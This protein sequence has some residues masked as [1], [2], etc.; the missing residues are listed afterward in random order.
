MDNNFGTRVICTWI[1]EEK[2]SKL[3]DDDGFNV[4]FELCVIDYLTIV[5]R[6][7]VTLVVGGWVLVGYVGRVVCEGSLGRRNDRCTERST[8]A[9]EG[10]VDSNKPKLGGMHGFPSCCSIQIGWGK[11]CMEGYHNVG[12]FYDFVVRPGSLGLMLSSIVLGI[13]S[14]LIPLML[15]VVG[16][17][18]RLWGGVNFI[19]AICSAGD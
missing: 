11:K 19:L 6:F 2:W 4:D 1:R 12:E 9:N 5:W 13:T 14:V 10:V 17:M 8:E 18:K 15:K 16:G 3:D 7:R